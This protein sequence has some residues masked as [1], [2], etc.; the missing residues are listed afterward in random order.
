MD[1]E[2]KLL[3]GKVLG[4]IFRLQK[5]TGKISPGASDAQIYGLLNGFEETVDDV[6]ERMGGISTEKMKAVMD[7][8]EPIWSN[9]ERLSKFKGYYDIE[10]KLA[11]KGVDRS[12]AISIFTYLKANHQ[13]TQLIQKMDSSD[14]P[15]EC[16][17]FDI[18][19]WE[20]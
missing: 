7:V 5:A 12:D 2:T 3:F 15:S 16:R 6:V 18:S 9:E 13:F 17:R 10:G 20:H 1:K 14:S 4:E 19:D 11:S 8:I